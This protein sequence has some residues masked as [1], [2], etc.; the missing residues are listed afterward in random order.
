[1]TSVRTYDLM[2]SIVESFVSNG[3]I[4]KPSSDLLSTFYLIISIELSRKSSWKTR[5]ILDLYYVLGVINAYTKMNRTFLTIEIKI[6][7][8]S[9]SY[10]IERITHKFLLYPFRSWINKHVFSHE[11]DGE[12][13]ADQVEGRTQR[14]P[15]SCPRDM[16][17][18]F[19]EIYTY[20]YIYICVYACRYI[21][22]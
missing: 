5:P 19:Q 18:N 21:Y 3:A 10:R 17:S 20:T 4:Y 11:R 12:W 9:A 8:A 2:K 14:E 13:K 6:Y 16:R 15:R 7:N 1:M 22:V